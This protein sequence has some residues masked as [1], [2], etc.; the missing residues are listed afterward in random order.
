MSSEFIPWQV[1]EDCIG[2][3]W[4]LLRLG[5]QEDTYQRV[6]MSDVKVIVQHRFPTVRFFAYQFPD[7][8]APNEVRNLYVVDIDTEDVL[9]HVVGALP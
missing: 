8:A 9:A 5:D 2:D 7:D 1:Y 3:P 6:R 4:V